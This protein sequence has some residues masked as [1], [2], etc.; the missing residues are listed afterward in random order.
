MGKYSWLVVL[1]A[2]GS[3]AAATPAPLDPRLEQALSTNLIAQVERSVQFEK[4]VPQVEA[5]RKPVV[6]HGE[7]LEVRD[8]VYLDRRLAPDRSATDNEKAIRIFRRDAR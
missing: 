5:P 1:L 4:T 6:D 8:G 2:T 3:A 7:M